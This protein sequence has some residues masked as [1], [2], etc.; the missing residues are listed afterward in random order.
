MN[1]YKKSNNSDEED[2]DLMYSLENEVESEEDFI[3]VMS[4][5]NV[6]YEKIEF[7]HTDPIYVFDF[8]GKKHIVESFGWVKDAADW[9]NEIGGDYLWQYLGEKTT[10]FWDDVSDGSVAYHATREENVE[11]IKK[12]GLE[13]RN[14]SRGITNRGTPSAVFASFDEN[15]IESYGDI[16]IEINLGMMKRDGYMPTVEMEEPINEC[17]QRKSLAWKIGLRDYDCWVDSSDGLSEET[18]VIFGKIPP[19]YLKFID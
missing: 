4:E 7:P 19:K 13:I 5:N 10:N 8:E 2:L 9:V 15:A 18:I 1:W 12:N 16:V 17:E 11:S 3:K 14:E 6:K